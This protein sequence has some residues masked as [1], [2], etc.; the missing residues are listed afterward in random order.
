MDFENVEVVG[1]EA[2]YHQQL[3]LEAWMSVKDRNTGN[4]HMVIQEV[5]KYS[6]LK[7]LKILSSHACATFKF[8]NF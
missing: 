2:H 8:K 6:E 3:F 4:D 1:H 5:Y 7:A